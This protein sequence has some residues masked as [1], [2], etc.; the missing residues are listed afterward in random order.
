ML[1]T[2]LRRLTELTRPGS[3]DREAQDELAHHFDLAVAEKVEAG[4]NPKEARR[5]ARL[6]LGDPEATREVLREGRLGFRLDM[7]IKDALLASRTLR[8]RPVFAAVCI[9]TIGLG[10]GASTALF[11]LVDAVV[12]RPLPL[13]DPDTLVSVY[14]ANPGKGIE[15]TGVTTGNLRDWRQRATRLQGVAGHYTMGRTLTVGVESEVV[16]TAQVTEGFFDLLRTKPAAGRIFT[17]EE[18]AA[19]VFNGAAAPVGTDLVAMISHGLW[20]RRFAGDPAV[21]ER[22]IMIDRKVFRIVG[23]TPAGFTLPAPD[24]Q[25]FLPWAI[26]PTAPRDQHYVSAVARLAPGVSIRQAEDELKSVANGLAREYPRTNE[27]WS[28]GLVPLKEDIVGDSSRTLFV[29]LAAVGLVLLVACA[30]VA[31]LSLARGLERVH[32]ASIR[33][34]LGASRA[35]LVGQFLVEALVVSTAGG[36]LGA[37]LAYGAIALMKRMA[38]DVPRLQEAALDPRALAFACAASAAAALI[39]G[40]PSA[41]KQSR[42]R[43]SKALLGAAV[44]AGSAGRRTLRDLLV[45]AEVAVA[46]VLLG[47]A[48]LLVRSYQQLS[49]VDPGFNAQG[50]LVAP[51]FLDMES[52]G[53]DGR[54]RI[55]YE[56]LIER[57]EAL[58]GVVSAGGATALP[59]S[60]LGPDFARPVWPADGPGDEEAKRPAWVRIV[61][62]RYFETLGIRVVEGRAF[63]RREG[64]DGAR[65]VILSEGVAQRLW[66]GRSAVGQRLV[67]DYSS[68]GTYP[69]EVVGV[70]NDVRFSGPRVGAREE[71]YLAH[72]QRPYLILNMA[73]RTKGDPRLLAPAVRDVLHDLDP[74][75]PAQGLHALEDLLGATYARDRRSMMVLSAF[76]LVAMLLALLGVHGML[77]HHVRERSREIG[78][79]MAIGANRGHVI[80]WVAGRGLKLS[81]AGL[82]I[83]CALAIVLGQGLS[84]LLFGVRLTDPAALMAVMALPLIGFVVSLHPAWRAAR[85]HPAEV[86]RA[87]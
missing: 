84:S 4:V 23:V 38:A 85:I 74:R 36:A 27:G 12:L 9:L 52:Y 2:R 56:T 42:A 68:A 55:Y 20:Q 61:T 79:R 33:L 69:Y 40:L 19:A 58:P 60:P 28:V 47:G 71:I 80:A 35:R 14:D 50:V 43:P 66:P 21:T 31:L 45:V 5:Q 78:I 1:K 8:K 17:R 25:I 64:P 34:A 62:P 72:A 75:K 57:L 49:A 77:S 32:E 44:F 73:V 59:A 83:G 87:G 26:A 39:S 37:A 51:I 24:V 48:S 13:P 7:F 54:S 67:V 70:V 29:L 10:V 11:A 53:G 3:L 30:N 22:T 16:L 63:D 18:T 65:A 86:L 41:W 81:L 46:V 76:A 15:R 6:E 82:L